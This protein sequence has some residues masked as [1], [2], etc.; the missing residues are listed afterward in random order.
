VVELKIVTKD[1]QLSLK[2][3]EN[4][5]SIYMRVFTLTKK[6]E[7]PNESKVPIAVR[8][9]AYLFRQRDDFLGIAHVCLVAVV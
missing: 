3:L 5:S 2:S 9:V 1:N 6:E 4:F 7:S 8:R